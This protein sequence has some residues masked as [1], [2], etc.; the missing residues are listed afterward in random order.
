MHAT[1]Q[2]VRVGVD[3]QHGVA[4]GDLASGAIYPSIPQSGQRPRQAVGALE[5]P[6]HVL[7]TFPVRL[8]IREDAVVQLQGCVPSTG[9]AA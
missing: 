4:L 9:R 7:A 3:G 5:T 6:P 8:K 1:H 2:R